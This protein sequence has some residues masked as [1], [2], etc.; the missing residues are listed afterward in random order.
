MGAPRTALFR[1]Q[2]L[3]APPEATSAV[4][5]VGPWIAPANAVAT[6]AV[7]ASGASASAAPVAA[8]KGA[9]ADKA[10]SDGVAP[11]DVA[12]ASSAAGLLCVAHGLSTVV[13]VSDVSSPPPAHLEHYLAVRTPVPA[14]LGSAADYVRRQLALAVHPHAERLG[15]RPSMLVH[16]PARRGK[17]AMVSALCDELGLHCMVRSGANLALTGSAM[18]TARALS[19]LLNEARR[20]SPCVLLLR[21]LELLAPTS[22]EGGGGGGVGSAEAAAVAA[23]AGGLEGTGEDVDWAEVLRSGTASDG[24]AAAV[25]VGA[26]LGPPPRVILIGSTRSLE[27]VPASMKEFFNSIV[28]VPPPAPSHRAAALHASLTAAGAAEALHESVGR[29]HTC[30]VEHDLL[31]PVLSSPALSSPLLSSPLLCSPLL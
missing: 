4:P 6:A 29:S 15:L 30:I 19:Q 31:S 14:A 13:Q 20:Y 10:V 28:A 26:D 5:G 8:D 3:V 9:A 11:A 7:A 12:S 27:A 2:Q 22:A 1:V 16:A 18:H 21:R 17:R 25:A 24:G 23:G